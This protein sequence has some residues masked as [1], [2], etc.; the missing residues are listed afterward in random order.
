MTT[1]RHIGK[2]FFE[3]IDDF[4]DDWHGG[5]ERKEDTPETLKELGLPIET[6]IVD[7]A[8]IGLNYGLDPKFLLSTRTRSWGKTRDYKHCL[9]KVFGSG[10]NYF[11][12]SSELKSSEYK[13]YEQFS[14][15]YLGF[16]PPP[17]PIEMNFKEAKE[18]YGD[19]DISK[20]FK[21][22]LSWHKFGVESRVL[23]GFD[24]RKPRLPPE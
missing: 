13:S 23:W 15:G 8:W 2:C 16:P 21:N 24:M 4:V 18:I 6:T 17:D 3:D 1:Q 14:R 9:K 22:G 10:E 5:F 19:Q 20:V 12:V 7:R 11:K